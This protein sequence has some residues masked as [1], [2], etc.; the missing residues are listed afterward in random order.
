MVAVWASAVVLSAPCALADSAAPAEPQRSPDTVIFPKGST[1]A[2]AASE[3]SAPLRPDAGVGSGPYVVVVLF[4]IAAGGWLLW[5]RRGG[6]I[7][8][9]TRTQK[10][11]QVEESKSLGNRQFLVVASYEDKRFLLG[12]TSERIQLLADLPKK[13]EERK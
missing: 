2:P 1:S 8:F 10:K 5:K 12:V 6:E 11:L 4:L 9:G 3:Q 13:E 7:P